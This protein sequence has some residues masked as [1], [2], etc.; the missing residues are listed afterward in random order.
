MIS[1]FPM[2]SFECL[3]LYQILNNEREECKRTAS[4]GVTHIIISM[5]KRGSCK[6]TKCLKMQRKEIKDASAGSLKHQ[7]WLN[8]HCAWVTSTRVV[9][10]K[11]LPPPDDLS[12]PVTRCS[13]LVGNMTRTRF[14]LEHCYEDDCPQRN[15]SSLLFVT[16]SVWRLHPVLIEVLPQQQHQQQQ[17]PRKRLQQGPLFTTGSFSHAGFLMA[18]WSSSTSLKQP[19][20]SFSWPHTVWRSWLLMKSTDIS[21]AK[22][23]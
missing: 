9:S 21:R 18:V 22:T 11:L 20:C 1:S 19:L 8:I 14:T 10:L 12:V 2:S 7:I 15:A 13:H 17:H 16:T 4:R 3:A 23:P 6:A 5:P